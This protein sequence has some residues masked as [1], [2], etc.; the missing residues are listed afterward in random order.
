LS[1]E[2]VKK[3]R[4]ALKEKGYKQINVMISEEAY[5]KLKIAQIRNDKNFSEMIELF[6][7]KDKILCKKDSIFFSNLK[8]SVTSNKINKKVD[9]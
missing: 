6:I 9:K 1:K 2:R 8:K 3:H 4:D 7:I 5:E